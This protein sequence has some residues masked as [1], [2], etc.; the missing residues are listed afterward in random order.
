MPVKLGNWARGES[1]GFSS[2]YLKVCYKA[3][4]FWIKDEWFARIAKWKTDAAA[5]GKHTA[6]FH[7]W[8]QRCQ[9]ASAGKLKVKKPMVISLV[10]HLCPGPGVEATG[11][12]M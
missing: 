9:P 11:I 6:H 3:D 10:K 1:K 2:P 7:H 4:R 5:T 12:A 8:N